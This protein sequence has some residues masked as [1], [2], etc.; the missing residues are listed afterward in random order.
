MSQDPSVTEPL[1]AE[2]SSATASAVRDV[3]SHLRLWP[4][5]VAGLAL[6]LWTKHWAF[7]HLD[8]RPNEAL[9]VI[10]RLLSFRRTLNDGA[11]FGLGKG[12]WAVFLVA[13]VLA[14]GFVWYLFSQSTRDRR[15]L[16][17]A[18]ALILAGALGN[19]Y[20]RAFVIVDVVRTRHGNY[21]G[22]IVRE[23]EHTVDLG[24]YPDKK[25]VQRFH[26]DV[27]G[28]T[29]K[30]QGVVRDFIKV[31]PRFGIELWPWVFNVADVLLVVGVGLLLLNF[32]WERRAAHRQTAG[33][34]QPTVPVS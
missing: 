29:V 33:G 30:R 5:A 9:Q 15:S 27:D 26:R 31:E 34:G 25:L 24:T 8:P 20:D 28:A 10:P 14:L 6:D 21:T 4:I 22:I 18:L 13:S 23:T 32:W 3:A 17:V 1:A 11:L 2:S 16:H 19:L 12:L 7:T